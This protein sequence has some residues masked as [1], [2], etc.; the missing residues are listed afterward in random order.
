MDI[1]AE[2]AADAAAAAAGAGNAYLWLPVMLSRQVA[3]HGT[4]SS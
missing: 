1:G 4:V 2:V 3:S